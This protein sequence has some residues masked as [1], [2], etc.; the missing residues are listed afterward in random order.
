MQKILLKFDLLIKVLNVE[1]SDTTNDAIITK[2]RH[3]KN[4]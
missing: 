4:P 1:V 3:K 2:A